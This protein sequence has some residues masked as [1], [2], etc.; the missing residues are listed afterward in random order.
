M[1]ERAPNAERPNFLQILLKKVHPDLIPISNSETPEEIEMINNTA[2]A[3]SIFR[4]YYNKFG[5]AP[6]TWDFFVLTRDSQSAS[7]F[8]SQT[9]FLFTKV[10]DDMITQKEVC[11]FAS[12]VAFFAELRKFH[13]LDASLTL[14]EK[15]AQELERRSADARALRL[16]RDAKNDA[17]APAIDVHQP[18]PQS[19]SPFKFR[20]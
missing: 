5:K 4:Q 13:D 16:E 8:N 11:S 7:G 17:S 19:T 20:R 9:K 6:D 1:N 15:R 14:E 2:T 10:E 12:P 18:K 3:F